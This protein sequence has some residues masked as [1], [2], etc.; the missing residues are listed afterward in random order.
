M[1]RINLMNW[2]K[3]QNVGFANY[4]YDV[5]FDGVEIGGPSNKNYALG[6][7]VLAKILGKWQIGEIIGKTVK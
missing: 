2:L 6:E 3:V 5:K 1:K 7:K 4:Y